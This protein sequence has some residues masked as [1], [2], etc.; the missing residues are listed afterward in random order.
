M[1][2]KRHTP[3][4]WKGS[5][6]EDAAATEATRAA[7]RAAGRTS[8]PAERAAEPEGIEQQPVDSVPRPPSGEPPDEK[9]AEVAEEHQERLRSPDRPGR[10]KL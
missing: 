2:R 8:V 5:A 6:V 7:D 9:I 1:K 4:R 10:G 3:Q